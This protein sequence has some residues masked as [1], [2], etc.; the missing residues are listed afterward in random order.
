[1]TIAVAVVNIALGVAYC[2]YGVMTAVE[3]KRDWRSFGFSHFGAAWIFMAFTCGPHHLAHGLHLGFEGRDGGL[4][5]LVTVVVG[6]P[7]GAMWL[8]LRVEAF[9]GGRGDRFVPGTPSWLHLVPYLGVAYVVGIVAALLSVAG[10]HAQVSAAA[11]ASA[12]LIGIYMAIGWFV[13]RT[14]LANRP[15]S[16]GWSVSGLCLSAIFPTCALMHAV[17]GAYALAG[18]YHHD[19]HGFV[20]DWLSIPAGL[21]FLWVIRRLYR[22]A[23]TDWNEG[24]DE[25]PVV[26]APVAEAHVLVP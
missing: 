25:V 13:T 7:V 12:A 2:G 15:S 14:Q 1:M 5:D 8:Y 19:I 21:Y 16:G 3:M 24:P 22:D 4:L 17:F 10:G 26:A 6:L 18:I 23:L 9:F 11:V 20:I